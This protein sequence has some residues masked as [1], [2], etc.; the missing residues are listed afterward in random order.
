MVEGANETCD[1]Q[2]MVGNRI[3]KFT[4]RVRNGGFADA[5]IATSIEKQE[6]GGG[7]GVIVGH[8]RT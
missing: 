5:V 7:G 8:P 3:V 1:V 2:G 4:L 6:I